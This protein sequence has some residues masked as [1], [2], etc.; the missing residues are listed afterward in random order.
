MARLPLLPA[1]VLPPTLPSIYESESATALEMVAKVYGATKQMVEDYNKFA[2]EINKE[3]SEFT[4]SSAAEIQN[5]KD[6]VERR[7]ACQFNAM[8]TRI[9][10]LHTQNRK[11]LEGRA[12]QI[13][14]NFTGVN[15]QFQ[16]SF[17]AQMEQIRADLTA[18]MD[19][20]VVENVTSTAQQLINDA[21]AAGNITITEVY[22]EETESLNMVIGGNV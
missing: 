9:A 10:E 22:D 5:F 15:E 20:L 16:Q 13:E 6:Y 7:L 3:I 18:Y 4:S 1:W 11:Y 17:I 19:N 14:Q 12:S 2:D 8:E 21:M